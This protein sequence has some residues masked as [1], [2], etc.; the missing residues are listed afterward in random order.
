MGTGSSGSAARR[1]PRTGPTV[2]V[3]RVGHRP[4]RDPRLSTHVALV[5]RA[6][7][8]RRLVLHPPD[9]GVE[10]T[11]RQVA[12]R[13]GGRFEV[14]GAPSWTAV[15]RAARGP[16]VH[17]TM[18]GLPFERYVP[19][20][21]RASEVLLVVGGAKVPARLYGEATYNLAVGDQPHSEVAAVAVALRELLGPVP[22][23]AFDGARLRIR[24][25]ARGKSVVAREEAR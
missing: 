14:V 10:R 4:G 6:F 13:W 19:R 5:A 12:E 3:L 25:R 21:R 7:G 18:Y 11:V 23:S 15:V 2:E 17:L 8:A 24:P 16:V 22:A 20:L 9:P 1:S